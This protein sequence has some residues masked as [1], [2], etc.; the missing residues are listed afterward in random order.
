MKLRERYPAVKALSFIRYVPL[1]ARA[2]FL[3]TSRSD[4]A[5]LLEGVPPLEIHPPGDRSEY[6]VVDYVEPFEANAA[7]LGLDRGV[8]PQARSAFERARDSGKAVASGGLGAGE[9]PDFEFV[10]VLPIYQ[11]GMRALVV[12]ERRKALTGFVGQ[13]ID[14]RELFEAMLGGWTESSYSVEV[15]DETEAGAAKILY[16][17]PTALLPVHEPSAVTRASATLN[18]AG[19]SWT[20]SLTPRSTRFLGLEEHMP[21]LFLVAG[22]AISLLAFGLTWSMLTSQARAL[23]MASAI[24]DELREKLEVSRTILDRAPDALIAIDQESRIIDWSYQAESMFG[25]PR[26]EVLGQRLDRTLIPHR[27]REAHDVGLRRFLETGEGPIL[28]KRIEIIACHRDGQELPVELTVTPMARG[29]KYIFSAFV[30]DVSSRKLLDEEL[31]RS[32]L[33]AQ[34]ESRAKSEFLATLGQALRKPVSGLLGAIDRLLESAITPEQRACVED[35]RSSAHALADA[36]NDATDFSKIENQ[37]VGLDIAEVEVRS[38]IERAVDLFAE[39]AAAKGLEL[40]IT[41]GADVPTAVRVDVGRL[42]QILVILLGN[43]VKSGSAGEVRLAASVVEQA[44]SDLVLR[45]AVSALEGPLRPER[46]P[47]LDLAIAK[48]LAHSLAGDLGIEKSAGAVTVWFTARPGRVAPPVP[49]ASDGARPAVELRNVRVQVV[50]QDESDRATL[51][52]YLAGWD[53]KVSEARTSSE[54]LR[55]ARSAAGGGAPFELW[56]IDASAVAAEGAAL[57]KSVRADPSLRAAPI[58]LLAPDDP[59][60]VASL[61]DGGDATAIVTKPVRLSTLHES[62]SHLLSSRRRPPGA[63]QLPFLTRRL[64]E[65]A[66]GRPAATAKVRNDERA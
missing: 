41:M 37:R 56:I 55:L 21:L 65:E 13:L 63:P 19:R 35:A 39:A 2:S 52:Q 5:F 43:A 20:L 17:E 1:E 57:A 45:I 29:N 42:E 14:A 60:I 40:V 46:S 10:L 12:E 7:L 49:Q 28:N 50:G 66:R 6:F 4:P 16:A 54:A 36:V 33:G 18:V 11:N 47:G 58:V 26:S 64:L 3:E 51:K 44:D 8:E 23:R 53:M 59:A 31:K 24:T 62:I 30:R 32:L 38:L 22:L 34:A 15:R 48:R 61:R 25:W 27:L 9:G